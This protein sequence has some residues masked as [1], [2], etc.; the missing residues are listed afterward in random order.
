MLEHIVKVQGG[1]VSVQSEP[2]EGSTFT[3]HLPI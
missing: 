2:E 3:I 1:R